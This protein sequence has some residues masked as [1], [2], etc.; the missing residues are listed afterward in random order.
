LIPDF[1]SKAAMSCELRKSELWYGGSKVRII[2][3][4]SSS[5]GFLHQTHTG[6][7]SLLGSS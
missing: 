2:D 1:A 3:A 5:C 7:I 6:L 4:A